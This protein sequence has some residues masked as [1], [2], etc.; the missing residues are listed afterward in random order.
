M[1]EGRDF[2]TGKVLSRRYE[3]SFGVKYISVTEPAY[4]MYSGMGPLSASS[5][6]SNMLLQNTG[7]YT[8][9]D[10]FTTK[11]YNV[12]IASYGSNGNE[13]EVSMPTGKTLHP[14]YGEGYGPWAVISGLSWPLRIIK[15]MP[16]RQSFVVQANS[17]LTQLSSPQF[18]AYEH[19]IISASVQTWEDNWNY[20]VQ[21]SISGLF[22]NVTSAP[23]WRKQANYI[24][25]GEKH[26]D[27][28]AKVQGADNQYL[29]NNF[30]WSSANQDEHWEYLGET[31]HV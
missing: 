7:T 1:N 31:D 24:W 14:S 12:T 15:V 22:E 18:E 27:G 9:K 3:N 25:N 16:D 2:F 10:D 30:D 26:A 20:R 4:H 17:D 29:E 23:T 13:Y 5:T 11:T 28:Y 19:P 8:F 21:N 6:N